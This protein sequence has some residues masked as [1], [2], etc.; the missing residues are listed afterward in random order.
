MNFKI[1]NF[2]I[3]A[4]YWRLSSSLTPLYILGLY[5]MSG[6]WPGGQGQLPATKM[7]IEHVN[8]NQS[9]LPGFELVLLDYDTQCN[10][11]IGTDMMYREL[12]NA[13]TTK[14]VILGA[15]CSIVTEPTA[16]SSHLWNLIQLSYSS[17]SPK[18]SEREIFPKFFRMYPPESVFNVVKFAMM[19][20]FGWKKVAT[21]HQSVDLF[22]L[23]T[24]DFHDHASDNDIEV[25]SS[26]S[27]A[28]NPQVQVSN[29]RKRGARIILG[30]FYE[31]KARQ[32]FCQAYKEGMYGAKY[33]WIVNGWYSYE[34]WRKDD[35]N[36]DCSQA[37]MDEAVSGSFSMDALPM[38]LSEH[39]GVSGRTTEQ[40][41][42]EYKDYVGGNPE[43]LTGYTEAPYGYDSVW[44]IAL[45][46]QEAERQLQLLDPPQTVVNFTYDNDNMTKLFFEIMNATDFE[47]VSG[48]VQF[49]TNGDRKALIQIKQIQEGKEIRVGIYNPASISGT[50]LLWLND[51]PIRWQGGKPPVDSIIIREEYNSISFVLFVTLT[52]LATIGI[53]L[54]VIFLVFNIKYR[55]RRYIKMSSPK[56]NNLILVGG[57]LTYLYII[58]NGLDTG[59]IDNY[60]YIWMCKVNAWV[61]AV[62]FTMAFGAMFSKTWRVHKIFTTKRIKKTIIK[63]S[64]LFIMVGILIL[65][66]LLIFTLWEALDPMG[67]VI[68]QGREQ[69]STDNS[70]VVLIPVFVTCSSK[71]DTYWMGSLLCKNGLLLIFGAFLAWE[72][73]KVTVPALNDSK[74]IGVSVYNIVILSF[75]GVPV[76]LILDDVNANYLIISLF[77]FFAATVTLCLV[78]IPKVKSRNEVHPKNT[79][80]MTQDGETTEQ[81]DTDKQIK[82]L[83][84]KVQSLEAALGKKD[85]TIKT[86]ETKKGPLNNTLIAEA[87]ISTTS[88][89]YS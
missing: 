18:L 15:G 76:S 26:E 19:K 37:Q 85:L 39:P 65:V 77:I 86:L 58:L 12:Y 63:D 4:I 5:P 49:N 89:T 44:T 17:A 75:V 30:S 73:R 68:S 83:T 72:T 43:S 10:G 84:Q 22:A 59:R 8:A 60:T 35:K 36:H 82:N 47:G 62:G 56:L 81:S 1:L 80:L 74:Y 78:F 14:V 52:T 61:L 64:Q 31:D 48:P 79:M 32:I 57:I 87:T 69:V 11:G 9:I 23:P 67:I 20:H 55:D 13:S 54:A 51:T 21:L 7:G 50:P 24:A 25:I 46:L 27:F 71:W 42:K 40:F 6:S 53:T 41:L 88:S 28:D 3:V 29:L 66:D 34:W 16:Q 70:D 45:M 33:V 2:L 38:S